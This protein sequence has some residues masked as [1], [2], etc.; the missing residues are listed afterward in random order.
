MA[1]DI[2]NLFYKRTL[3]SSHEKRKSGVSG[4]T[5]VNS[6]A[7]QRGYKVFYYRAKSLT[8]DIVGPRGDRK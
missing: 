3:L 2:I 4:W 8:A 6:L 7:L 5:L 1:S